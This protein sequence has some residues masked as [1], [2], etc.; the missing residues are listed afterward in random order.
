MKIQYQKV[1][2]ILLILSILL[3]SCN[4]QPPKPIAWN[5]AGEELSF[6]EV[7]SVNSGLENAIINCDEDESAA[8]A[9]VGDSQYGFDH[10][11]NTFF[12]YVDGECYTLSDSA[13]QNEANGIENKLKAINELK[14]KQV[15]NVVLG[16]VSY[17]FYF[18]AA[19]ELAAAGCITAGGLSFGAACIPLI[20]VAGASLITFLWQLGAGAL[21]WIAL[22]SAKSYLSDKIE[23]GALIPCNGGE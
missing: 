4:T 10:V 12:C 6:G 20:I 8:E 19:W 15:G 16:A 5:S 2:I 18:A 11:D 9:C 22:E 21:D 3:S 1:V 7:D 14:G 13:T 17:G 23:T